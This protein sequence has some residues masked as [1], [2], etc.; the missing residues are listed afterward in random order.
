MSL[1][2]A[3]SHFAKPSLHVARKQFK[4]TKARFGLGLAL[5]KL[6]SS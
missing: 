4:A 3:G 6:R 2:V 1:R 5:F